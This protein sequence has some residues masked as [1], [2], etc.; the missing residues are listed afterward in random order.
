LNY[1]RRFLSDT[2]ATSKLHKKWS[3]SGQEF[4]VLCTKRKKGKR[5]WIP[6][7]ISMHTGQTI[8]LAKRYAEIDLEFYDFSDS[9]PV[10]NWKREP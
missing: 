3:K 5:L 9:M 6:L 10:A 2:T 7:P 4:S 1:L 8:L